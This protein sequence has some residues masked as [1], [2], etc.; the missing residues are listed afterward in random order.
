MG[1]RGN[2]TCVRWPALKSSSRRVRL[3][4]YAGGAYRGQGCNPAHTGG[5]QNSKRMERRL[6][7]TR[8]RTGNREW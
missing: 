4:T 2:N 5:R 6:F 3:D 7:A 1:D 8:A